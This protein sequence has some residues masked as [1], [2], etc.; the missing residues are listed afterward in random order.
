MALI[1]ITA[2]TASLGISSRTLRYYEQVGLMKSERPQFEKYRFYDEQNVERLQQIMVLRK[3]QIP[4]KDILLIYQRQDMTALVQTFVSR[5]N[6]IDDEIQA[7]S[8]LK[9]I[10]NEFLQEMLDNGINHISA[11]PLLY[12]KMDQKLAKNA[13]KKPVSMEALSAVSEKLAPA[14]DI[15]IVDLPPMR[16]LTSFLKP[17]TKVSD[18]S[19]F[20]RYIQVNG[21]SQATSGAHRQFEFQTEAGDVLMVRVADDFINESKYLDYTFTGELFAVVNVYLD[22]DLGQCFRALVRKLDANS[23]YQV[24]YCA[25]GTIRH[26]VMLENLI[27]PNDQRELVAMLVPVKKRMANSALFDKPEEVTGITIA[28]IEAANPIL[29]SANVEMDKLIPINSPHYKVNENG[30]AEYIC[31]IST[32]LLS[33]GTEVK[34]P[35]RLDIDFKMDT[36]TWR[37]GYGASE[38][39][40]CFYHDNKLYGINMEGDADPRISKE[41]IKFNHP[42]YGDPELHRK[43]G[44]IEYN[45]YN[46]LTWIV[47][48]KHFA[49]IINGEV[50]YCGM[51]FPYMHADL[52][53]Q[54]TTPIVIGS[55]GQGL[56][57]F[58]EIR[59]SQL[60]QTHKSK[61]KEGKL[62]M[63]TKQSNNIIPNIH[64]L[65]T[66]EWGENY[67]FCGEAKYVMECLSEPDYTYAFFAGLT[68][69]VL[70]Q[71]Y[72]Y[73]GAFFADGVECYLINS[74]TVSPQEYVSDL[75]AKLGYAATF[76]PRTELQKNTEMYLRT[77]VAF[78]DKGVPVISWG[79]S[80]NAAGDTLECVLVG[81]EEN[82]RVLLYITGDET[83]PKRV[84]LEELISPE[85][86][87]FD[88]SG[89]IFVGEKQE[90]KD[91]AKIYR[92]VIFG[93]PNLLTARNDKFCFGAEAF[94]AWAENIEIGCYDC[95][96]PDDFDGWAMYQTYVCNL[97]TNGS[98]CYGF[99][100][101]A[102]ELNPDLTWLD[103]VKELY[104]QMGNMWNND[105]GNDLE[106]LGGGFNVTLEVLQDKEKRKKIAQVIR[107]CGDC[108]DKVVQIL[109]ENKHTFSD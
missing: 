31:Y 99:L 72:G 71:F 67:W 100:D 9:S 70:T 5:I 39:S 51:N 97:A 27:S 91:L 45:Q 102:Q 8:E 7:L 74:G 15:S 56:I 83:E 11:L 79:R 30:E 32:R 89:W 10:V 28:E 54:P 77:L 85:R 80:Y 69:S 19:E 35:F 106:S 64:R 2:L 33:T 60:V 98:C 86:W 105:N 62:E 107:K 17:D 87:N 94:R 88:I 18:Y 73:N 26:P 52:T 103:E 57:L 58:K 55:N 90:Q 109:L 82:G 22:E 84:S 78:I 42:I 40:L 81:Y 76:V 65:I 49:V 61:I 53:R 16:V 68:G 20:M 50:R 25:D 1:K 12:E 6:A 46:H 95:M 47:G 14:P 104:H 63:I 96:K 21:L 66:S 4:I 24:A 41:A 75:F 92:D 23:Y 37:F 29:W 101:K 93:L 44:A 108:M 59:V 13:E 48:E 34:L 38:G 3:M 36:S 43:I